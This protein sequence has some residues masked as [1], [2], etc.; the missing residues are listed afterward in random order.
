MLPR[1]ACD[2]QRRAVASPRSFVRAPA[3]GMARASLPRASAPGL[4]PSR[5][6]AG[7][8]WQS[9]LLLCALAVV[10][11]SLSGAIVHGEKITPARENACPIAPGAECQP[12]LV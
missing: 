7:R 1:S 11:I 4:Q 6:E 10:A 5:E 12:C 2:S 9:L 8:R 3:Y